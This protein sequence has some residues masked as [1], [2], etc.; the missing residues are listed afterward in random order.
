MALAVFLLWTLWKAV[1]K[2]RKRLIR[3][4]QPYRKQCPFRTA[5]EVAFGIAG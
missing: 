1:E 4:A 5:L 3:F 2:A